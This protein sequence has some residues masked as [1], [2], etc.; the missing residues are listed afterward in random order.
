[1][2]FFRLEKYDDNIALITKGCG[3][4][5]ISFDLKELR[6]CG[7]AEK[8]LKELEDYL[9]NQIELLKEAKNRVRT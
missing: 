9:E 4:C 5:E 2:G 8:A 7:E 3:C 6:E 1:M